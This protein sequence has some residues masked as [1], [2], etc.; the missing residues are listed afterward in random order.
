MAPIVSRDRVIDTV[1]PLLRTAIVIERRFTVEDLHRLSGVSVR[2][3]R[4]YMANDPGEVREPSLSAALS[5]A[6]VIGPHAVN[7]VLAI[8]GY[9]NA[10]PMDEPDEREPIRLL[11]N[12][13]AHWAILTRCAADGI[14]D[15]TEEADTTKAADGLIAELL[16]YSSTGK[17]A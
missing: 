7:A 16:P 1:R 15:H 12:G 6:V 17:A 5:L 4:S 11:I 13:M 9:G 3:I 10:S 14:I 8:I 2:T